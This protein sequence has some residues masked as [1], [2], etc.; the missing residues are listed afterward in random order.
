LTK[1]E[2]SRERKNNEE[3][4]KKQCAEQWKQSEIR[5]SSQ[6]QVVTPEDRQRRCAREAA[7]R[8]E[9]FAEFVN[10]PGRNSHTLIYAISTNRERAQELNRRH[11]E[12]IRRNHLLA[13]TGTAVRSVRIPITRERNTV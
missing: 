3:Q 8:T 7:R 12:I 4:W 11:S 10:K 1:R 13:A 6:R 5:A 2:K 9:L